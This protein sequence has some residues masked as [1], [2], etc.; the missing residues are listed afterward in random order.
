MTQD[1]YLKARALLLECEKELNA[2]LDR[3]KDARKH[4]QGE[5]VVKARQQAEEA[6]R[7]LEQA[8]AD[9]KRAWHEYWATQP[10]YKKDPEPETNVL[11]RAEAII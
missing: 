11:M 10:G 5:E 1:G 8:L 4:R 3:L 6:E 9:A 7:N 2:A